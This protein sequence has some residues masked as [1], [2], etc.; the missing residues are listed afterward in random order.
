MKKKLASVLLFSAIIFSAA[1]CTDL[2]ECYQLNEYFN[3]TPNEIHEVIVVYENRLAKDN[4]DYYSNLAIAILYSALSSPM[5][6]P[7][8]GASVKIVEYSKKFEKKEKNNPIALVYYGLGCSLVSRDSKNPMTQLSFVKKGISKFDLAVKL[9][10]GQTNEWFVKYMRANF[11]INLPNT[12]KKRP[13]AEEDFAFVE[14]H[15]AGHPEIEGYMCNGYF[16]LG[17]IEKS[18]GNI[19]RAIECWGKSVEIN[20]RLKLNSREASKASERLLLFTE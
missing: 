19:A 18:R 17:E 15:Y 14:N 7:E 9:S 20:E 5:E 11:Y 3:K 13:V 4:N 6:N 12:F 1:F 10:E 2:E 16:N 8:P